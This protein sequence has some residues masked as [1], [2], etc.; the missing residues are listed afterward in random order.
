MKPAYDLDKIKFYSDRGSF[1][2]AVELYEKG[3]V[4]KFK[5]G[6]GEFSAVVLGSEPYRVWV[7]ARRHDEGDCTCYLG[8]NDTLCKHMIAVAIY[9]VMCGKKIQD[10]DKEFIEAPASSGRKGELD[11]ASLS[12]ARKSITDALK[13]IKSYSGPSRTWFAYQNSL[14][15]G[16]NRLSAIISDLP[17]SLQTAKLLV[18]LLLRIDKK[19]M[20]GG[21]D[22][23]DGAVGG[24]IEQT[25]Q[26]LQEYSK[27]D[28]ECRMAFTE[29]QGRETC[30]GWEEPLLV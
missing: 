17:I 18:S 19:L 13:Y 22:D 15:E 12:E 24:F 3:K 16:C 6:H 10:S 7:S 21:V 27:I 5:S 26:I 11:S 23:S 9:A 29:L 28:P 14:S 25:V 30:F 1:E 2:R 4:T 8:Q 20:N